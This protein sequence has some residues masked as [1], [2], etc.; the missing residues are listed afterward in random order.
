M[1]LLLSE[2]KSIAKIISMLM[3]ATK[4]IFLKAWTR[5]NLFLRKKTA[6]TIA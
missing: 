6:S 3:S 2:K 5:P 1:F 4:K